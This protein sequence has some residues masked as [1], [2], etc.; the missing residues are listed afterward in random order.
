MAIHG[1]TAMPTQFFV[2][3]LE[4]TTDGHLAW[5]FFA[6]GM[7]SSD[8]NTVKILCEAFRVE[9]ETIAF[10]ACCARSVS[11]SCWRSQQARIDASAVMSGSQ[12]R[13]CVCALGNSTQSNRD[14]SD[15]FP[16]PCDS[17]RW[18]Q[19]RLSANERRCP[20]HMVALEL[21]G[22]P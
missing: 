17:R 21:Q 4:R 5:Y 7:I 6:R 20:T 14:L 16:S 19:E 22:S 18:H 12:H 11:P 8:T 15:E 1:Q 13:R 3:R 10:K 9:F 2:A